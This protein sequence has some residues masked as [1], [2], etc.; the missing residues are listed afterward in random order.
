MSTISEKSSTS[1]HTFAPLA[2]PLSSPSTLKYDADGDVAPAPGPAPAPS[3]LLARASP[4]IITVA[5]NLYV[6]SPTHATPRRDATGRDAGDAESK[7]GEQL[8]V[9]SEL[10]GS[11]PLFFFFFLSLALA[12]RLIFSCSFLLLSLPETCW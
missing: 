9:S 5:H 3:P 4:S 1:T 2:P 12:F 11:L 7:S 8:E 6:S 10:F